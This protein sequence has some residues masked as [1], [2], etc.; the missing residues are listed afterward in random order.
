M[1]LRH[2]LEIVKRQKWLILEGVVIAAVVAVIATTLS[3][4]RYK[5]TARLLLH[6]RDPAEQLDPSQGQ[7]PALD[8]ERY[9][10]AQ[11]EVIRSEAVAR[12]AAKT[13][14]GTPSALLRQI[15]VEESATSDLIDISA[16]DVRAARARDIAN[17]FARAYIENRRQH[18]VAS[19]TR[20]AEDIE[21]KLVGLQAR[22]AE[23]DAS[24]NGRGPAIQP[25]GA[26]PTPALEGPGSGGQPTTIEG[27]RAARNAAAVQYEQ[28]YDRQQEL[29]VEVGL[30]R[31]EAEMIAEAKTPASPAGPGRLRNGLLGA[32]VGLMLGGGAALL[33]EQL[34]DRIRSA[35][36]VE[37]L[38]GL[39]VMAE[40]AVDDELAKEPTSLTLAERPSHPLA[41]GMRT[42][43][44]GIEFLG[45]DERL[46]RL[47]VTSPAP[48]EGKSVVA[49]NLAAACAEAG[50]RTVLV[51]SDLRRPSVEELLGVAA[52]VGLT[53]VLAQVTV[54][55]VEPPSPVQPGSV[56]G[57]AEAATAEPYPIPTQ[58]ARATLPARARLEAFLGLRQ[59]PAAY[60]PQA[61]R[62]AAEPAPRAAAANG[63]GP[64]APRPRPA[65]DVV[66]TS[67][68]V[69]VVRRSLV[70][71]DVNNLVLLP[72]G[73]LPPN[74]AQLLVS[75]KATAV[76]DELARLADVIVLD[77]PP[78]LAVADAA[79]LASRADGVLLVTAFDET[80]RSAISRSLAMLETSGAPLLGAVVNKAR[81]GPTSYY[82]ANY[83]HTE[84]APNTPR[85]AKR[86]GADT[87]GRRVKA[88]SRRNHA[89]DDE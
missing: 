39:P 4:P 22:I 52:E 7:G 77:T 82:Y 49:A 15:S 28:L 5:A 88:A 17:A 69:E 59:P 44:T 43:R 68:G 21:K 72:A 86:D 83:A 32:L 81:G 18:A 25:G 73:S 56:D 85:G 9:L 48:G 64:P 14:P 11:A 65:S 26:A 67:D 50:H 58:A 6:P 23:L 41:E 71:T 89:V 57:E 34:D 24:I 74:P 75:K 51:S 19:L 3:T 33:R 62:R 70:P 63:L 42:V 35:D 53:D 79:I 30:K 80:R 37:R 61:G 12:E 29:L 10:A 27:L 38:T 87:K 66:L 76:L 40:L 78:M 31:G 45:V 1:E 2:Y 84:G 13:V 20:V 47:V 60:P 55:Q 8:A 54:T 36:E 46:A 16:T